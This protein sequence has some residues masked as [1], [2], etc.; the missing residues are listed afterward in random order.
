MITYPT[1]ADDGFNNHRDEFYEGGFNGAGFSTDATSVIMW[2]Y[3]H[4]HKQANM[5]FKQSH[6]ART[7]NM[8]CNHQREI[9]YTRKGHT[10]RYNDKTLACLCQQLFKQNQEWFHTTSLLV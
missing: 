1:S 10:S 9:L 2:R 5:G 8:T 6:P 3:E 7:Y 4:N